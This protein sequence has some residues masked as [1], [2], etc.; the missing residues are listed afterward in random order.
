MQKNLLERLD[1]VFTAQSKR[2]FFNRDV[3]CQYVF[4]QGKVPLNPFRAFDYFLSDRVERDLV[5]IGNNNLIRISSELWVFGQSIA[6]GV[7]AEIL[8]ARDLKLPVRYFTIASRVSEI[9]EIKAEELVFEKE[10]V[11]QVSSTAKINSVSPRRFL[12][13]KVKGEDLSQPSFIED[14]SDFFG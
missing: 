5:R 14:E 9:L 6:D 11:R 2:D 13:A 1:V 10:L 12:L 8:F 3:V 4:D 7:Y